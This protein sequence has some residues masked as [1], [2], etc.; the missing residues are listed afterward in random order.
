MSKYFILAAVLAI[1]GF[2]SQ[3]WADDDNCHKGNIQGEWVAQQVVPGEGVLPI[4]SRWYACEDYNVA[5]GQDVMSDAD[6][7]K[8]Y[9]NPPARRLVNGVCSAG[10]GPVD[11]CNECLTNP[12][13]DVCEYHEVHD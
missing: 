7:K 13:D 9:T 1:F 2:T 8:V 3:T 12:P 11:S 10:G 4:C 6:C 5:H